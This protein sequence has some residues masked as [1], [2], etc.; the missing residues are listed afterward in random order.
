MTPDF[1]SRSGLVRFRYALDA[2]GISAETSKG[3]AIALKKYKYDR[4]AWRCTR[5]L[6]GNRKALLACFF[7]TLLGVLAGILSWSK[8]E[9][10]LRNMPFHFSIGFACWLGWFA[11]RDVFARFAL[12]GD[13]MVIIGRRSQHEELERFLQELQ[14]AKLTYIEKQVLKIVRTEKWEAV[15][16]LGS[17]RSGGIIDEGTFS[18][19]WHTLKRQAAGELPGFAS[20]T[21]LPIS[22]EDASEGA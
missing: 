9:D 10:L 3:S 5:G 18:S 21:E 7:F 2:D 6:T 11:S 4:L 20:S 15:N 12:T 13:S 14:S 8:G 19:I 22:I 16:Y 17:L 1:S